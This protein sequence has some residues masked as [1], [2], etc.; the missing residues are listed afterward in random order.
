[1]RTDIDLV[2]LPAPKAKTRDLLL[3]DQF[4]RKHGAR[5]RSF[6]PDDLV[7]VQIHRNNSWTW[8]PAKVI[9]RQGTVMYIVAVERHEA[10][11]S[12]ARVHAN[13]MKSRI[14][15][16]QAAAEP[17]EDLLSLINQMDELL[18]PSQAPTSDQSTASSSTTRRLSSATQEHWRPIRIRRLPERFRPEGPYALT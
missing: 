17:T 7:Y 5:E 9:E 6:N 2:K 1:M 11:P 13:Q 8:K 15:S 4:N 16:D 3:E 14:E 10:S 12:V 18:L